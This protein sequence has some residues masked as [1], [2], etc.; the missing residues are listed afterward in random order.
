MF[1]DNLYIRIIFLTSPLGTRWHL[2]DF[3]AAINIDYRQ[4]M[5]NLVCT[6]YSAECL[7]F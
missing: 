6:V 7:I 4:L 5:A 3:N 1:L 2:L